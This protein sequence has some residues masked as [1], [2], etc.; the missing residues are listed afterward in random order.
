MRRNFVCA[1]TGIEVYH[2]PDVN[3]GI[4]FKLTPLF[5]PCNSYPAVIIG[6][7]RDLGFGITMHRPSIPIDNYCAAISLTRLA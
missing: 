2:K 4:A 6:A 7:I 1:F 5:F 3:A